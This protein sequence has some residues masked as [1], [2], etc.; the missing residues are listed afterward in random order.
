MH[1]IRDAIHG[2]ISLTDLEVKLLDT[3][4]VQ[5][6][7]NIRQLGF[8]YLVYPGANHTRFEHSLGVCHLAGR[9]A[10]N[11][12]LPKTKIKLLRVAGL[13]HDLGHGPFSHT[14]ERMLKRFLKKGHEEIAKE[15]I[16]KSELKSI[17]NRAGISPKKI[18]GLFAGNE[19]YSEL[20]HSELDVDRMD[21]LVRD[22]YYTG[23]AYG[24]I[25]LERLLATIKLHRGKPVLTGGVQAAESLL[26]ARFLM[27]PSVYEHHTNRI[28]ESMF[29]RALESALLNKHIQPKDLY[30]MDDVKVISALRN[31]KGYSKEIFAR[32]ENRNLFKRALEINKKQAGQ[33][34]TEYLLGIRKQPDEISKLEKEICETAKIDEGYAILD[35]PDPL[36]CQRELEL[37]L[38]QGD[39][40]VKASDAS[41]SIR[42]LED[43]QWDYWKTMVFCPDEKRKQVEKA[44]RK[45]LNL[46]KSQ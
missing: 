39:E 38:K 11:L 7:R 18:V 31:S 12:E 2:N 1:D 28:A 41:T 16:M 46:G 20:L 45:V 35:I 15:L 44:A 29:V 10:S 43:A 13:L 34:L 30:L 17:L 6:L 5:R 25:D 19:K 36:Y 33:P 26:R 42:T 24:L 23:V 32:I 8:A 40:L 37:S 3:P 27:Y 4:Q 14:S 9:L 21:Y 22:S